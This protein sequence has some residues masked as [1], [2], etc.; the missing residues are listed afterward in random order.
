MYVM[1]SVSV[2]KN[3][4]PRPHPTFQ[5]YIR[6]AG[7]GLG[8]RLVLVCKLMLAELPTLTRS[9]IINKLLIP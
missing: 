6:K 9:A 4:V 8:M 5:C 3:L 1:N 2:D 7:S